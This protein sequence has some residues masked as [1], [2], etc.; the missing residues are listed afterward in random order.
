MLKDK[1]L[2]QVVKELKGASKMHAKQAKKVQAH[3]DAMKKPRME[4]DPF[5]KR[6]QKRLMKLTPKQRQKERKEKA[7]FMIE[8]VAL[9]GIGGLAARGL[10]LAKGVKAA[11]RARNIHANPFKEQK[12][13]RQFT[14]D[15]ANKIPSKKSPV[16]NLDTSKYL[17]KNPNIPTPLKPG[18]QGLPK[19]PTDFGKYIKPRML[20]NKRK[21]CM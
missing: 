19:P 18:T 13:I 4:R 3:I 11:R 15:T 1:E 9:R 21:S 7:H 10:R 6:E 20:K 2:K 17:K 16:R 8:A 12:I 5:P 14:K